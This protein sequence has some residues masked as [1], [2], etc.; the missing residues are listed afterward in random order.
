MTLLVISGLYS[1]NDRQVTRSKRADRCSSTTLAAIGEK[2]VTLL[3]RSFKLV[4]QYCAI[5]NANS[6]INNWSK[7]V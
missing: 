3:V 5:G 7:K 4:R 1:Q 6:V 2:N